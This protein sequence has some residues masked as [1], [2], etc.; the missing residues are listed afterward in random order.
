MVLNTGIKSN[1]KAWSAFCKFHVY[2]NL[3]KTK[4]ELIL[5]PLVDQGAYTP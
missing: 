2:I 3:T 1:R 5:K 4:D